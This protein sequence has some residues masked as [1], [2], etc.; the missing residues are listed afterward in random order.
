[1]TFMLAEPR[2]L[3]RVQWAEAGRLVAAR[4]RASAKRVVQALK[5]KTISALPVD[6]PSLRA[7]VEGVSGR[8]VPRPTDTQVKQQ[9]A[10]MLDVLVF[11]ALS[12]M[13]WRPELHPAQPVRFTR[14]DE[15]IEPEARVTA[16]LAETP[17]ARSDW[18]DFC[19]STGLADFDLGLL[20][21]AA[22][23]A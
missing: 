17:A 13:G 2:A 16:L 3:K 9:V 14:G 4:W 7:V 20:L 1:M 18:A 10:V 23:Q 19:I 22:A 8:R 11:A 6:P 21:D 15:T 5:L 12:A